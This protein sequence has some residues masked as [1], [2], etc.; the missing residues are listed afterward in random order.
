MNTGLEGIPRRAFVDRLTDA[1][2]KIREAMMAVEELGCHELL[3]KAVNALHNAS[4]FTADFID[5]HKPDEPVAIRGLDF[6]TLRHANVMRLPLFKNSKGAPAHSEPDGSD[7]NPAQWLQAVVGELGEYANIRKKFER[8]DIDEPT[9]LK[10]AAKELADVQA[11]LD[12]LAFR[13]GISLG[14]ATMDKWNLVS[15]RIGIALR[16]APNGRELTEVKQITF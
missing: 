1:E 9:F 8:G 11:Y 13:L 14:Q 10:E 2:L 6:A 5:Q 15:D 3:T 4:N 16:I 7:W 12:I